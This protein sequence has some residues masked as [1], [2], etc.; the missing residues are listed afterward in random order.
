M[1]SGRTISKFLAAV[2]R[3]VDGLTDKEIKALLKSS[4]VNGL[5]NPNE[6]SKKS[7][8]TQN[9]DGAP[10]HAQAVTLM[11]H[12]AQ[13]ASREAATSYLADLA[14]KRAVLLQ[15]AKLRE[16]HVLKQDSNSVIK[17]KLVENVVGSRLDSAVIRG[18]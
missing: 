18:G 6:R 14:P 11:E 13:M 2:A 16:V 1:N 12:L 15:A 7:A 9:V 5:F 3:A 4:G 10:V 8:R 17:D